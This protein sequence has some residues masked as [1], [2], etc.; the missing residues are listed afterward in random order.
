MSPIAVYVGGAAHK[1]LKSFTHK[2]THTHSLSLSLSLS[3][4]LNLDLDLDRLREGLHAI[5]L[6]DL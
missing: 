1:V 3:L 2:H 4:D 6:L 5:M